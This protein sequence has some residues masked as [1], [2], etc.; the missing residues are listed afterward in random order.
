LN[1]L[2]TL[3]Q[4]YTEICI[5]IPTLSP[6]P[7]RLLLFFFFLSFFAKVVYPQANDSLRVSENL[8]E[9]HSPHK[10]SMMSLILPG[11]GQVYNRKYWKVPIIY[12]GMGASLYFAFEERTL[13]REFKDAYI[14]RVDDDP[15]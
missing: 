5:Y 2:I 9:L 14:K 12:A 1:S 3:S 7:F 4:Y 13:F 6:M 8:E 15:L 10:A 11:L